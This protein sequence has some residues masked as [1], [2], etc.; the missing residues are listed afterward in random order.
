MTRLSREERITRLA[1]FFQVV[2][3]EY[4]ACHG[5]VA[6]RRLSPYE[7]TAI[8][9]IDLVDTVGNG[10]IESAIQGS[11]NNQGTGETP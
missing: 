5:L 4:E 7:Y 2:D 10:I 3:E 1:K 11:P 8:K 6:G 9:T